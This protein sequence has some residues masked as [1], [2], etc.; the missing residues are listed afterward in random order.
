MLD[1]GAK[2]EIATGSMQPWTKLIDELSRRPNV[3]CKLSGLVTEAG[4]AWT[5]PRSPRTPV[6]CSTASVRTG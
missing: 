4:P 3:S 5:R 2:P 6:T 1:H